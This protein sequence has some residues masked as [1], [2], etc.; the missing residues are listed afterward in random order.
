MS[1]IILL[2]ALLATFYTSA[3]SSDSDG[4]NC[5]D[6]LRQ[7][8]KDVEDFYERLAKEKLP[9]KLKAC[10][11]ELLAERVVED[12]MELESQQKQSP[13]EEENEVTESDV[14]AEERERRKFLVSMLVI[15]LAL[16]IPSLETRD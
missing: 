11:A 5:I 7:A 12:E 1:V 8:L 2:L 9:C 10:L 4:S 3:E 15:L 13:S 14:G 6:I 16:K